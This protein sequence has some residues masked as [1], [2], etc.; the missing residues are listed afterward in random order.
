MSQHELRKQLTDQ[1]V[2]AIENDNLLPWRRSWSVSANAGRSAN[3]VSRKAYSGINPLLLEV[4]RLKHGFS[5]RWYGT[6]QQWKER[7]MS[8]KPRPDHVK[9]GEWGAKVVFF[10]PVTK[11]KIDEATG[12][13]NE[14]KFFVMRS[15]NVFSGDQIEGDGAEQ[16]QVS[17]QEAT[18][19]VPD[20]APAEELIAGTE[21]DI[22]FGGESAFYHRK[23]DYIQV[24]HKH[25]FDP[26]GSYYETLL[27]ELSHWSETRL[28]WD[29]EQ[30]GYAMGELVAEMSS[31]FLATELG[32]PQAEG[33]GNHA[34]YLK[35]WLEA[36]KGD[37]AFLFRA[38]T[39]ASKVADY[40]L[41]FRPAPVVA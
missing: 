7:G 13:V 3:V 4:H 41:S 9:R 35:S 14:D 20:F 38:S 40:L 23:H 33:L 2:Q 29:H 37:P 24:P 16:F 15:Y 21:A 39:Q 30:Q 31:S 25:R 1:I 12:D 32:V 28:G 22:R 36:I 18:T 11:K 8:V 6:F 34:A 5:S 17:E 26:P 19:I 10:K 27:H